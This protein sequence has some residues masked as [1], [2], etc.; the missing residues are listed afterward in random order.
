MAPI[1]LAMM[2][3]NLALVEFLMEKYGCHVSQTVLKV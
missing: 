1:E 2:H 3:G